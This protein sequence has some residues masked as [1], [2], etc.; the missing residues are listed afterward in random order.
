MSSSLLII[1][2]LIPVPSEVI[3]DS[4]PLRDLFFDCV[5]DLFRLR[6]LRDV[7]AALGGRVV[8]PG[9]SSFL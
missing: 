1:T 7:P 8:P 6:R 3:R 9:G 5:L 4:F 2:G